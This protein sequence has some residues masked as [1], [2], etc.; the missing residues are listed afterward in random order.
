[1]FLRHIIQFLINPILYVYLGIILLLFIKNH[2]KKYLVILIFYSY[3]IA[4][5][6]TAQLF[7]SVW[8]MPHSFQS[9]YKYDAVVTLAGASDMDL[10]VAAINNPERCYYYIS[11]S[12]NVDRLI[13]AIEFVRKNN[14]KILLLGD[15]RFLDIPKEQRIKKYATALNL[16]EKQID[17]YGWVGRTLDEATG[18]REYVKKYKIGK[19]LLVTT[20]V[21]MRRSHAMFKK[22]GLDVDIFS[23]NKKG[24]SINKYSFL[25]S[26][27]GLGD[28]Y[29]CLYELVGYIGYYLNGEL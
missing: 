9:E 11:G 27:R 4:I 19:I 7:L 24:L 25:P 18:V 3:I 13:A 17:I 26:Y 5:P 12:T 16:K 1:M 29:D 8:Q 2:R 20:A 28:T 15:W 23:V 22:Q 10:Y 21:H 14:A 6:L